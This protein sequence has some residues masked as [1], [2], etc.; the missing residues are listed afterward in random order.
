MACQVDVAASG[1][2]YL[3]MACDAIVAEECTITGSIGVVTAKFNAEKLNKNI[4]KQT[5]FNFLKLFTR[6]YF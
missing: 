5:F 4:G 1:G 6:G 3:S 2:Y